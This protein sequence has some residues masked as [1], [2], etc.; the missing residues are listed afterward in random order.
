[1]ER[2]KYEYET[3]NV[4]YTRDGKLQDV[5]NSAGLLGW[6]VCSILFS[7]Y[8]NDREENLKTFLMKRSYTYEVDDKKQNIS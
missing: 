8:D 4:K 6:E 1:M 2:I 5:L 3:I 7:I